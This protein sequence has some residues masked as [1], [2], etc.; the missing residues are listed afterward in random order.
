MK[1]KL[2]H[3]FSKA[4]GQKASFEFGS[5]APATSSSV[6]FF[7]THKTDGF[8][9]EPLTV[10]FQPLIALPDLVEKNTGEENEDEVNC[11]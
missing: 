1:I 5:A 9:P 10:D 8:K 7:F 6:P 2:R 11:H 4:A 3:F